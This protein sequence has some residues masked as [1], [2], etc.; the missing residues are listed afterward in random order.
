MLKTT[1][2]LSY[3][4]HCMFFPRSVFN[5]LFCLSPRRKAKKKKEKGQLCSSK[6]FSRLERNLGFVVAC[7]PILRPLIATMLKIKSD[8]N[9]RSWNWYRKCQDE[10]QM[11]KKDAAAKLWEGE[12]RENIDNDDNNN[13][14]HHPSLPLPPKAVT[15]ISHEYISVN[16]GGYKL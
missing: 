9:I 14:H 12:K 13:N 15:K 1:T 16:K 11:L 6:T 5:F 4:V 2:F 10:Q 8:R 3:Y 7:M